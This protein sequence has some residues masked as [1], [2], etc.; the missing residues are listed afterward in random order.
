MDLCIQ[1]RGA[2]SMAPVERRPIVAFR[3]ESAMSR[4]I[5]LLVLFALV[6]LMVTMTVGLSLGDLQATMRDYRH[7]AAQI[8]EAERRYTDQTERLPQLRAERDALAVPMERATWHRL[9]GI[10]TALVVILVNCIVVTY[11]I[12]TGR[13]CR[14]V[15]ETYQLGPQFVDESISLKRRAIPWSV[16]GATAV[17][18]TVALGGS[19]D[20]TATG[21]LDRDTVWATAHL[22]AA[23]ATIVVVAICFYV[24]WIKVGENVVVIGKI[25]DAVARKQAERQAAAETADV[26]A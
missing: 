18:V 5:V 17:I 14:E 25:M 3:R 7:V 1:F 21:R 15:S 16:I 2:R 26:V 23:A 8:A 19:A 11:F 13:W 10:A 22:Y 24:Q 20:P 12:G 9:L 4:I 6:M